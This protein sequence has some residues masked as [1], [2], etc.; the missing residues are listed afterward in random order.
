MKLKRTIAIAA[1][2]LALGSLIAIGCSTPKSGQSVAPKASGPVAGSD[3]ASADK[4]TAGAP[5]GTGTTV[6]Y[7][8]AKGELVCPVLGD[9]IPSVE[10]A[11]GYQD[12]KG[13]RYYFCCAGCPDTFAKDPDAYAK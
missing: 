8:N 4:K 12:Y 7:T 1:S 6:A 3:A 5:G 10:K 9:V 13:K 11:A 2:L